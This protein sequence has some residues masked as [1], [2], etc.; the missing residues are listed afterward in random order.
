MSGI[1]RGH[2]SD[3]RGVT[4]VAVD[5]TIGITDLV[6]NLH[7]TIQQVHP[8]VG[9]SR[10]DRT[11]GL[12]GFIYRSI[13]GTTRL[14][15]KGIDA[16]LSPLTALLPK[17]GENA[18]R[19]AVA[20]AV[21]GIYGDHLALTGNPLAI[22]MSLRYRGQAVDIE[23]ADA[24]SEIARTA[25]STGK[26]MVFVHGLCLN[27]S[28]WISDGR[29]RGE[30]LAVDL[31][32]AP[33]YLRYNTGLPVANNGRGLAVML[34]KVLRGWPVPVTDLA[35][36][37]HSMGGLVARSACHHGSVDGHD[38]L[39]HLRSLV[40]I[41]TPHHGAP[42]ERGGNWLDA[43][44]NLS[45]Y[46]APFTRIGKKRSAGINDLQHGNITDIDQQFIPLSADVECYA[47]AATLGK[48]R[49]RLADRLIGDGLVP[50][51]SALGKSKDP[52]RSLRF[53]I[54]R[55]WIGF[56]TG[57]M[58][59]LRSP[60]VYNQLREWLQRETTGAINESGSSPE[61]EL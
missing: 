61:P 36:I 42:L 19:D 3:L 58:A 11:A 1:N 57:H 37:G 54:R 12:T 55:Q 35:L 8:P 14:V 43:V 2:L 21:N 59:L 13:R 24:V 38:W 7:H 34:E 60:G 10:A 6:E 25:E 22:E 52:E 27:E 41:G 5:A 20:S 30:L 47:M 28:H 15:G 16:G 39:Q 53:P 9:V 23:Q 26:V 33:L 48:K 49:G 45:P 32:Y 17:A 40:S 50:L 31:G 56:E 18:R 46:V 44:M 29:N 51:D 4:R